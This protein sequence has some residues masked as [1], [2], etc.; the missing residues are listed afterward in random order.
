MD[1]LGA[2]AVAVEAMYILTLLP[3]EGVLR[4]HYSVSAGSIIEEVFFVPTAAPD[5]DEQMDTQHMVLGLWAGCVY[6]TGQYQSYYETTVTLKMRGQQLGYILIGRRTR[7]ESTMTKGTINSTFLI[8]DTKGVLLDSTD[9]VPSRL[10][11]NS[12]TI[13]DPQEVDFEVSYRYTGRRTSGDPQD[14]F[15][16]ALDALANAAPHDSGSRTQQLSGA[17]RRSRRPVSVVVTSVTR[18]ASQPRALTYRYASRA[19]SLIVRLMK[20]SSRFQ[21]I[22]IQLWYH[23]VKFGEGR[24]ARPRGEV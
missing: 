16:A 15:L 14:I 9:L 1:Q 18:R 20:L 22:E 2:L 17:S 12:G 21:D 11:E 6:M 3:W 4:D 19:I 8:R 13:A 7:E 24:I 23:N 5:A 10:T